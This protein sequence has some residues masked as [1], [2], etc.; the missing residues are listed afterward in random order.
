MNENGVSIP[1]EGSGSQEP[2][3]PDTPSI[4]TLGSVSTS[5][6]CPNSPTPIE[7]MD[8]NGIYK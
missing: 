6:P 5:S 8:T 2:V 3:T 1:E 4:E 7:A